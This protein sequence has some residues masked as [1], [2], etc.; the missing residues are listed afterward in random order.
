M[1][2]ERNE[3]EVFRLFLYLLKKEKEEFDVSAEEQQA[4]FYKILEKI[5]GT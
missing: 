4:N 2:K 1:D 3:E 5:K